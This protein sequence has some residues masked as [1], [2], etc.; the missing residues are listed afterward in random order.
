MK[1]SFILFIAITAIIQIN[2][3]SS[4]STA[5]YPDEEQ[6]NYMNGVENPDVMIS[7]A[8]HLRRIPGVRVEGKGSDTSITIQ[9]IKT[10]NSGTNPLFIVDGQQI[11]GTF[12]ELEQMVNQNDIKSIRVLKEPSQ[13]AYYGVLG[14]NGVI[15]IKLKNQ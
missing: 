8:D 5:S 9:G 1:K 15:D 2:C 3:S 11:N 14:T 10:F 4:K 13:L 6:I 12:S 7:L